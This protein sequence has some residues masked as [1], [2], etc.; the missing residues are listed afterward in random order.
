MHYRYLCEISGEPLGNFLRLVLTTTAACDS[1][2]AKRFRGKHGIGIS[3]VYGI[4]EVGLPFID[5]SGTGAEEGHAGRCL[6]SMEYQLLD[7][8]L[9][10]NLKAIQVRGPGFADAYYYP[11][12]NREEFAPDGWF[13]TGDLGCINSNGNLKLMGRHS[14]VLNVGGRKFAP[15]ELEEILETHPDVDEALI[16]AQYD[17]MLGQVPIALIKKKDQS[18]LDVDNFKNWIVERVSSEKVPVEIH[19]IDEI[20]KTTSGKKIRR[21]N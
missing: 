3:N 17:V 4:I 21:T 20:P 8:G 5:T 9:G 18:S 19:F 6:P 2:L 11:W 16:R 13:M 12:R 15:N 1:D 14:E 7:V 10:D